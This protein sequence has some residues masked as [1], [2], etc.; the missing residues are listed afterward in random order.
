MKVNIDGKP[1]FSVTDETF[2]LGALALY[3]SYN[4]GSFFDDVLVEDLTTKAV[5][6]W[7][8]FNDAK[9]AG[10]KAFDDRG[11]TSGPSEW[12]VANGAL[13]QGSNI[14]SDAT[15]HPGTFLLY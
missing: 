15:G 4:Q 7:D 6:L 2:K 8:D 9:L 11:T 5:L 3:S 14:G 13:V 1:V 10:W 12:S